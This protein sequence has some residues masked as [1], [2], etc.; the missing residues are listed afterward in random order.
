MSEET[1]ILNIVTNEV[2]ETNNGKKTEIKPEIKK[3]GKEKSYEKV[4]EKGYKKQAQVKE[5]TQETQGIK[6]NAKESEKETQEV[7]HLEVKPVVQAKESVAQTKKLK[8]KVI[9][10]T[11]LHYVVAVEGKGGIRVNKKNTYKIGDIVEV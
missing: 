2:K 10:A 9:S 11:P 3:E 8:G 7:K 5:Q 4:Y 6:A 1:K